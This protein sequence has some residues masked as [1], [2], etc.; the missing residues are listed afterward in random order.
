QEPSRESFLTGREDP[1]SPFWGLRYNLTG[2]RKVEPLRRLSPMKEP[3][4]LMVLDRSVRAGLPADQKERLEEFLRRNGPAVV[5]T[6]DELTRSL[7]KD[8]P[9]LLY[10]LGHATPWGLCL[11]QESVSPADLNRWLRGA[12][13]DTERFCG[14]AFLNACQ[15][16]EFDRDG[17]FRDALHAAGLS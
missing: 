13:E 16:A 7:R 15:T 14:L 11:G 8:R 6:K 9:D 10:W 5:A 3:R 17:S 2:G 1:W 12:G 4:L